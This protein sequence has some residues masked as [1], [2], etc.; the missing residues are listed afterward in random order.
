[1]ST[2]DQLRADL[3]EEIR[4]GSGSS[5]SPES[6][7]RGRTQPEQPRSQDTAETV[8][9]EPLD[10]EGTPAAEDSPANPQS[11]EV[12]AA[13]SNTQTAGRAGTGAG[14]GEGTS[15]TESGERQQRQLSEE[16]AQRA[17]EEIERRLNRR[18]ALR[19]DRNLAR[20][21]TGSYGQTDYARIFSGRETP[22]GVGSG[23]VRAR[24]DTATLSE[25][26]ADEVRTAQTV[27][28]LR[29]QTGFNFED[30]DVQTTESGVE[31]SQQGQELVSERQRQAE[32]AAMVSVENYLERQTGIDDLE[33]GQD[34]T[35]T[36]DGR[37]QFTGE[38]RQERLEEARQQADQQFEEELAEQMPTGPRGQGIR[39]QDV[40]AVRSVPLDEQG[41]PDFRQGGQ[42]TFAPVYSDRI[43]DLLNKEPEEIGDVQQTN[44]TLQQQT[45]TTTRGT[46]TVAFTAEGEPVSSSGQSSLGNVAR[47]FFD[48]GREVSQPVYELTVG[49]TGFPTLGAGGTTLIKGEAGNIEE[50]VTTGQ[51]VEEAFAPDEQESQIE[52]FTQGVVQTPFAL[53]G[54]AVQTAQTGIDIAEAT[55][56]AVKTIASDP[57]SGT[58]QVGSDVYQAGEQAVNQTVQAAEESPYTFS[59]QVL[60]SLAFST[61]AFSAAR[62]AG[63][64]AG[65]RGVGLAIQPGE[66]ILGVGG[67]RA[68]SGTGAAL[69]RAGQR[70]GSARVRQAGVATSRAGER[71]FPQGEP[72][73]FSEET[74]LR[75]G[76]RARGA[77]QTRTP[78]INRQALLERTPDLGNL[79]T[80][81][82]DLA[83]RRPRVRVTRG[84]TR[85]PEVDA[86]IPGVRRIDAGEF[87]I[88]LESRG[89]QRF[90]T[91]ES[92]DL[93]NPGSVFEVDVER[94]TGVEIVDFRSET[95]AET[96]T[97]ADGDTLAGGG[98][99]VGSV[100]GGS[101]QIA[102]TRQE[103]GSEVETE[104]EATSIEVKPLSRSRSRA[105]NVP[106]TETAIETST[107]AQESLQESAVPSEALLSEVTTG[108][109]SELAAAEVRAELGPESVQSLELST[110]ERLEP[111]QERVTEPGLESATGV[112]PI[113][114][115]DA[116]VETETRVDQ[117]LTYELEGEQEV[118][119]ELEMETETER[120]A[121]VRRLEG[122]GEGIEQPAGG[123]EFLKQFEYQVAT[124]EEVLSG[125]FDSVGGDTDVNL[126]DEEVGP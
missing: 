57:V 78:D 75:A 109:L 9:D 27:E 22:F 99:G 63:G 15:Q 53:A 62:A 61:A 112:E 64:T 71:L 76:R 25:E 102:L 122:D 111:T 21:E 59:G 50:A 49:A 79:R 125:D 56:A 4:E 95:D 12:N 67:S 108:Q 123:D 100:S 33:A 97:D 74:A 89:P 85:P 98:G 70:A 83:A 90:G 13:P 8:S 65:R 119:A 51:S 86:A 6:E 87:T 80:R 48:V 126:G 42:V 101:G 124:P 72:I 43:N 2:E 55:P 30:E 96:D 14:A 116:G 54:G 40:E 37:V 120:E 93:A 77:L 26:R 23:D 7:S 118:E 3:E 1:M 36:A 104:A 39:D 113:L 66:E 107:A 46:E 17:A 81:V 24:G 91:G 20:S 31:L 41:N 121:L 38:F 34:F 69:R 105:R 117:E 5:S 58:V 88:R 10:V 16:N 29:E 94:E 47:G 84:D 35:I 110:A 106:R 68:F 45:S 19:E 92:A 18:E 115:T 28:Q 60:G 52:R 73:I 44:Q 103:F 11:G 82:G 32:E 114:E